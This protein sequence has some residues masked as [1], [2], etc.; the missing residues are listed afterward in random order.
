[1]KAKNNNYYN[2]AIYVWTV[3]DVNRRN[4]AKQNNLNY[5]EIFSIKLDECIKQLNN[6]IKTLP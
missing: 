4:I 6:Y 5:L 2:S 3:S 1:M